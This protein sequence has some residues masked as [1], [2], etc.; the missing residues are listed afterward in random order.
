M[1]QLGANAMNVNGTGQTVGDLKGIG[2][3]P[4]QINQMGTSP[5]IWQRLAKGG[6]QGAS[7]GFN[8]MQP[9]RP[10]GP[11][12]GQMGSMPGA[13]P[14]DPSYFLPQQ[15]RKPNPNFYGYGE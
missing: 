3:T 6:L 10:M 13:Q 1:G 7:N 2:Y 15:S 4:D 14:V 5:N 11:A 9:P 12:T 8:G